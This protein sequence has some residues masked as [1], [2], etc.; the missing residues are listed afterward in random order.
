MA[1][2]KTDAP[3]WVQE[4]QSKYVA[5]V[6][7]AFILY[8]NV[9][10]YVVPG[11]SMRTYLAKLM[12]GRKIVAFYNRSD[13]ITFALP[14]M[15]DEFVKLLDLQKPANPALAALAA[16]Q[17]NLD[18]ELPKAPSAALPLLARLLKMGKPDDKLAAV[19]IEHAE[20]IVPSADIAMMSPED[21]TLL[22]LVEQLGRDPEIMR[23]GN[24]VILLT[25]NLTDLHQTIRAASSKF[26]AIRAPL[27]DQA[28]RLEFIRQYREKNDKTTW[29]PTPEQL[30]NATAGLSLI[31]IEDIFL[32]AEQEGTLTWDLVRER[33]QDIIASEFGEVLEVFDPHFGFEMIG[34]LEH[35][36]KFF[37]RCVINPIRKNQLGLVPMGVLMTGPAG[38]G[39]TA[40]AEAV[41]KEAGI[42]CVILNP[43]R[44][45]GKYVGDTERN[46]DRALYAILAMAPVLVFIDEIDQSVS[47]G[48]SGDSGV[49]NRFFKRLME[50]MSDTSHRG[51]VVF[52]AASNRPDLMDP[53]LRRPG[54]FDKKIPF[55]IPDEAERESIFAVMTRKYGLAIKS[56]PAECV[57]KADG[58]TGAEIELAT[59]KSLEA[60][61]Y[62][63]MLPENALTYAVNN[64]RPSTADIEYM[65]LLA[66]Q[67]CNERD[68]LPKKYQ[69][70]FDNKAD[71]KKRIDE[72]APAATRG[73]RDL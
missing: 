72:M 49:S 21:R 67:E 48:A 53:A 51:K 3:A 20:T 37:Q 32:R 54:R 11:A 45:F 40:M 23:S 10:D 8:F 63:G 44:I 7:H 26:E 29:K 57:Q 19:M 22:V 5:G 73:K 28:A 60:V 15:R 64:M 55:L 65:T 58:W 35:V 52:L 9:A 34:G 6:S 62:D 56:V 41:A 50:F 2:K 69:A 36:K 24:P 71:L 12:A 25:A 16:A 4:L 43:A 13:G 18:Q 31:H 27:P 46:L 14:S 39:K 17:G 38:T 1:N 70:E 30:A 66:L 42:N 61:E 33:K 68:L 47:R 59:V